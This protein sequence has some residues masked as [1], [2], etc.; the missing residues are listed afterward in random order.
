MESA[1]EA[2]QLLEEKAVDIII[3]DMYLPDSDGH[4]VLEHLQ[5]QHH[6]KD[7]PVI[8]Y[9]GKN[10]SNAEATIIR[11]KAAAVVEKNVNSY[12]IL[13]QTLSSIFK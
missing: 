4:Q 5:Q 1:A 12:R 3:L 10:L 2:Y 9:T 6:L 8:I 13:V 11:Q 7:I